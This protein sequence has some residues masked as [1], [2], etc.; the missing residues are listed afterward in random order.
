MKRC[1][2]FLVLP[3]AAI[4]AV[5]CDSGTSSTAT[6][7]TD[8]SSTTTPTPTPTT[9]GKGK[10]KPKKEPLTEDAIRKPKTRGDL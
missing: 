10:T 1:S 6:D 3:L 9:N 8:T 4:L 2:L 7:K 5:G